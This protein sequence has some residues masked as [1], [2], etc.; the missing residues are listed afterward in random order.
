MP[1]TSQR[2]GAPPARHTD[3]EVLATLAARQQAVHAQ[4]GGAGQHVG[5]RAPL[6]WG[7]RGLA[8]IAG[9]SASSARRRAQRM[10]A[11]G[12]LERLPGSPVMFRLAR[13]PADS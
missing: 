13:V 6:L 4:R 10:V 11:A 9:E 3:A 2:R 8:A 12:V 1:G 5:C 7:Y